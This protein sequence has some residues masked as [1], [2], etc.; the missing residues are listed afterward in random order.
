MVY[1]SF[2]LELLVFSVVVLYML[3]KEVEK[4]KEV[5]L[6]VT[7]NFLT[8]II[9]D[10]ECRECGKKCHKKFRLP[11]IKVLLGLDHMCL[12]PLEKKVAGSNYA[13]TVLERESVSNLQTS[14]LKADKK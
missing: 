8:L 12:L 6:C 1:V 10:S 9:I 4:T 13:L 2:L 5:K 7:L 11:P 3:W 14:V